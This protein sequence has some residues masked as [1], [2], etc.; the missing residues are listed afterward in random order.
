MKQMIL[1]TIIGRIAM[2]TRAI[3]EILIRLYS[4][5]ES[6]GTLINDQMATDIVCR[7]CQPNKVFIDVGAHIGS[8]IAEVIQHDTSIEIIAIEAMPDKVQKLKEKFPTAKIHECAAGEKES[9]SSFFVDT[10]YSGYSSLANTRHKTNTLEEGNIVEIQVQ[11]NRLDDIISSKNID[12]I[13]IDVEGAELGVLIGSENL[14]SINRPVIMFESA[15]C[16][17][18]P[19]GYTLEAMWNWLAD[20]KYDVLIPNRLAHTA[21]GLSLDGFIDSHQ[22]PRRTTNYFAVPHERKEEIMI[23]AKKLFQ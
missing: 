14:I 5:K 7:L 10:K 6:V 23:R 1:G 4:S 12:V 11:I 8:I 18:N 3:F 22:Y 17:Q 2:R 16:Q 21:S 15:P 20:H 13:K 19:L 9:T